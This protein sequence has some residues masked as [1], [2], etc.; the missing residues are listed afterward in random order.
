MD[1]PTL[2]MRS[3]Q[4]EYP[5]A[6]RP[7][8]YTEGMEF[9]DFVREKC[10]EIGLILQR[11]SSFKYQIERGDGRIDEI[12]LDARCV[13]TGRLSIEIAEKSKAANLR[14]VPS[15][16]YASSSAWLYIQGNYHIIF[17]FPKNFLVMLHKSK[18]YE[19]GEI[20][21]MQKFYLPLSD[22]F[23]YAA[24]VIFVDREGEVLGEKFGGYCFS[25]RSMKE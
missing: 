7:D 16:I 5:D 6:K 1:G 24:K 17:I 25:E 21:T 18:K 11:Y 4:P 3:S 8:T 23:K 9:E 2:A 19:E 10:G 12:K 15:G 22:A 13:D 20:P 14:F